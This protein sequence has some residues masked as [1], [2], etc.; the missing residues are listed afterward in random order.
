[1]KIELENISKRFQY[2]W[3]LKKV[4]YSFEEDSTH[5][6]LGP[7]GSGKSTLLKI[8]SGHLTPSKGKI[9]FTKSGKKVDIDE[10]SILLLRLRC[11]LE[12]LL[13]KY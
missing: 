2:D 5:A 10:V 12:W 1:M 7:N 11:I 3:I 4:N 8:L 13:G 9:K 6:I